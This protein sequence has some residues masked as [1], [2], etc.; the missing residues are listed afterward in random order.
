MKHRNITH[1][2]LNALADTPV[3]I[4]NGA[5]QT[6]KSTL[7]K[8]IARE[9]YPAEY[10]T[11]DDL[12]FLDAALNDPH[13]FINRL[14]KPVV[15]DE[16]QKAPDLFTAIKME[17]DSN[18]QP[19]TF[20]LT[21]SA[22]IMLLPRLSDS[23]TGRME[24][25]T[26]WPFSLG[27]IHGNR[28]N[29]IDRLFDKKS[30]NCSTLPSLNA[31]DFY[32]HLITGGYPEMLNRKDPDRQ[33]AWFRSY[34]TTILQR[35]IREL[36]NIE[37]LTAMPRLL[38]LL[39]TRIGNGLNIAELSRTA[40]IPQSTLKRY[41]AL[42]ETTFLLRL[43]PAWSHNIGKRLVRSPKV[44]LND[45]GLVSYLLDADEKTL[46]S[47]PELTGHLIE[48]FVVMECCKQ[49]TWNASNVTPFYFRTHTG[50]EVDLILEDTSG[51]VVALEIKSRATVTSR[52]FK[53]LKFLSNELG[54]AFFRGIVLYTGNK[55]IPFGNS[56]WA[57]PVACVWS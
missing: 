29:F 39:A 6:G 48:N 54:E 24:I 37:G 55:V 33:K 17:V 11:L 2:I 22:D 28:E 13:G 5:R 41:L 9:H 42:F 51:S 12:N 45:S 18:R 7:V 52:D 26:L 20:L 10:V 38:S 4:L 32:R 46:S 40:A 3:V 47:K 36:S 31:Q 14:P 1:R 53:A 34:V 56:M 30:L 8:W 43:L 44:F 23:L 49:I 57:I 35:D 21:G 50:R 25:I 16:I 15:I 27:E 19:G